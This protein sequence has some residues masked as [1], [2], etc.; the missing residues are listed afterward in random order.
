MDILG[1]LK[2]C[3]KPMIYSYVYIVY[4]V[5]IY[6]ACDGMMKC[7]VFCLQIAYR[8]LRARDLLWL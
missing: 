3:N 2:N 6:A 1:E 5:L 7:L 4:I 8:A